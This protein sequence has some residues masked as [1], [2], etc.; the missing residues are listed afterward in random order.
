MGKG[1]RKTKRGK[2]S[3]GTYGKKRL[4]NKYDRPIISLSNLRKWSIERMYLEVGRFDF[5]VGIIF[6]VD[7]F[8]YKKYGVGITGEL[9]YTQKQR[10]LLNTKINSG[11]KRE[12]DGNALFTAILT[13]DLTKEQITKLVREGFRNVDILFLD[14]YGYKHNPT[15][16]NKRKKELPEPI[17]LEVPR[18]Q[19]YLESYK[20]MYSL[21]RRR[22]LDGDQLT[23]Y[24]KIQMMAIQKALEID[25]KDNSHIHNEIIQERKAEFDF[26]VEDVLFQLDKLDTYS[27][28]V[29]NSKSKVIKKIVDLEFRK[30][31]INPDKALEMGP[32]LGL[33]SGLLQIGMTY[34]EEIIIYGSNPKIVLDFKGFMHVV[35]RHCQVCNIGINNVNKTR[36][37][38]S[39]TD[40]KD[41]IKSCLTPISE[42]IIDHYDKYPDRR[43]SRYRDR[44]IRF[45][46][47]YY[48]VHINTS[49][50]IETFYNNKI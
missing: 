36:I 10:K 29:M 8:S 34:Q 5:T 43:F 38:Y 26:Q 9:Y 28:E 31:G 4:R 32:H 1:D 25:E 13:K 48:E 27:D 21:Y 20:M 37:P 14:Y 24:E 18:G 23:D 15:Y 33:Y 41:L 46:G 35:F 22:T 30:A 17:R 11:I 42:E 3:S 2:L 40:I 7:S 47:D 45:N 6:I 44:L 39:L 49:G 50:I 19:T 16:F 12:T